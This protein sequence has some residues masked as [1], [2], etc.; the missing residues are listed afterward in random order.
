MQTTDISLRNQ[1]IY[2]IYTRNHTEAGTLRA[3]EDDLER[4]KALGTDIIW[5]MPIH[6]VGVEGKKGSLGCPYSISDYRAV[7]PAYGTID[8]LRHLVDRIHALGMKCIID[9]VYNHTSRDAVLISQHPE[10]YWK[11]DDGSMGNRFGDWTDVYDL[12]YNCRALWD[13]QVQTLKFWAGIVD[14]FRCDV[15]SCVP[16]A[17]WTDARNAVSEVNPDCIWLA[18][19]VHRS[20]V[21]GARKQGLQVWSDSEI[22]T[23]FDMEY[24]YDIHEKFMACFEGRQPLDMALSAYID[25]LNSQEFIYPENY[26][27]LRFVENHDNERFATLCPDRRK[28]MEW[29]RFM[30][31][32]KGPMLVYGGQ[33]FSCTH[34]P[35]LFEKETFPRTGE[36]ISATIAKLSQMKKGLPADAVFHAE[37]VEGTHVKASYIVQDK[38]VAEQEFDL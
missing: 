17:F 6:P 34:T 32:Q 10:F 26:V 15:A 30:F 9:V 18:E 33:E 36:D 20:F 31:F 16:P 27:K 5:L 25:A 37:V 14:G 19:T 13:Y 1:T 21:I 38:V 2:S 24:Q 8:D 11:S 4:I 29:L 7:N 3:V 22:Y 12:D 23:A 35:S 28:R